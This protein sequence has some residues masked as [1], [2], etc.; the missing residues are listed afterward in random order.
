MPR[1]NKQVQDDEESWKRNQKNHGKRNQES[2]T[3]KLTHKENSF[4]ENKKIGKYQNW[5][6]FSTIFTEHQG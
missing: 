1:I 6:N 3:A 2:W 4:Q 5:N